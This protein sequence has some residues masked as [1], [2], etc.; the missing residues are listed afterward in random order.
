MKRLLDRIPFKFINLIYWLLLSYLVAALGW[1]YIELDQQNDL[2]LAF[3]QQQVIKEYGNDPLRL[4][5]VKEAH[6]RNAKQYIGE[7]LTFLVLTL[8]G[9]FFVY[10]AVRRQIK[11]HQQQK[12]FMMAVTHELKTPIA[13]T[14]LSLETLKRHQLDPEKQTK[15]LGDAINETERLDSLCNNILLS[16]Q[17]ESGGYQFTLQ[18]FDAGKM[19][20][21]AVKAFASRFPQRIF[22]M[23]V[24]ENI[25]IVGEEFLLRLVMN[26]LIENAIKYAP[27]ALPL[28]I[29]LLEEE[30]KV[31]FRVADLGQ[32]IPE[33]EKQ[34]IFEKFYR[35]EDE[36]R[37]KTKGTG[38]GLYLSTKIVRD[39]KGE[40]LLEN[41]HPQGSVFK[42]ILP[43]NN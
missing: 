39:H 19:L 32:G 43:K 24:P 21:A 7:G 10:N 3:Q 31:E 37:R 41:N 9:A 34:K 33:T 15:I 8:A 22:E 30:D 4:E 40:L 13:V 36:S 2:M 23:Q 5:Q 6:Q 11:L 42:V 14:K 12:N 1:W 20:V 25:F 26:N 29:S 28:T 27:A 16:S 17:L 38:L 35:L 18:E